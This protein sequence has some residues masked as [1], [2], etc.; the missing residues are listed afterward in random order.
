MGLNL[1]SHN[2]KPLLFVV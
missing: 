1:I 2:P